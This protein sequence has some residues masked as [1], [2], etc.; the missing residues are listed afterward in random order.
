MLREQ[1]RHS[2]ERRN[3]DKKKPVHPA[4]EYVIIVRRSSLFLGVD[5]PSELEID[6]V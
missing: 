2:G 5:K 3:P 1:F 4:N 6:H